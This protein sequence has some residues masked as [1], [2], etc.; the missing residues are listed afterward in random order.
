MLY[1]VAI[2]RM[3]DI[4]EPKLLKFNVGPNERFPSPLT[5]AEWSIYQRNYNGLR[6]DSMHI[7]QVSG[8]L[9][10]AIQAEWVR[11]TGV[12]VDKKRRLKK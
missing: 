5:L 10:E 7:E 12:V 2:W 4:A 8:A 3:P 11:P 1:F 6:G 9:Y